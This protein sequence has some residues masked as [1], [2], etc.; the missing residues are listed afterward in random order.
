MIFS[1]SLS[2][3]KFIVYVRDTAMNLE[4]SCEIRNSNILVINYAT[5]VQYT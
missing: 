5:V 2:I 4:M 3:E 1:T